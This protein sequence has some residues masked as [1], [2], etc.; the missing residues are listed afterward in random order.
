MN[1]AQRAV[2]DLCAIAVPTAFAYAQ[3]SERKVARLFRQDGSND[4]QSRRNNHSHSC[5]RRLTMVQDSSR[6]YRDRLAMLWLLFAV[7]LAG[8]QDQPGAREAQQA[9]Q[10]ADAHGHEH[11]TNS[12]SDKP[13]DF[14]STLTAIETMKTQ[15]CKA[16]ADGVPDD[17]HHALHDVGHSLEK[18]PELA[19]K[20]GKFSAEQLAVVKE[21]V[22]A[23]FDGFGKLDV[24]MHGGAE[25][26][27]KALEVKLTEALTKLKEAVK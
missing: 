15:I 23:L 11:A 21:A 14:S 10:P 22:E 25:V 2:M 5:R 3:T 26:D 16:F 20:E 12:G 24:T 6:W 4:T 9:A 27:A 18:L 1:S 8:C 17:A 13:A 7:G 19:A